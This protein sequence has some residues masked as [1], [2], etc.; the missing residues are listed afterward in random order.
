MQIPTAMATT[1]ARDCEVAACRIAR[2][3][4]RTIDSEEIAMRRLLLSMFAVLFVLAFAGPRH[5][6]GRRPGLLE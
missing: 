2:F 5:C 3:L 6:E 1:A 4:F